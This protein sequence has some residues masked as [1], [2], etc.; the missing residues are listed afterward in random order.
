M[1]I[2]QHGFYEA[3]ALK[4]RYK[5]ELLVPHR[6]TI[7]DRNGVPSGDDRIRTRCVRVA[8]AV[9]NHEL[10]AQLLAPI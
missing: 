8:G 6:G 5:T 3:E 9:K 1:Q 10:T 4:Q 2:V 7:Y